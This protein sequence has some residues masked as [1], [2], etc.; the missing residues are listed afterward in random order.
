MSLELLNLCQAVIEHAG[1]DADAI[2]KAKEAVEKFHQEGGL[3]EAA[4]S[5]AHDHIGELAVAVLGNLGLPFF[6]PA[7]IQMAIEHFEA[8]G[9][10]DDATQ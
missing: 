8:K 2:A 3:A 1:E 4:Q 6:G 7:L 10:N 5:I 9:E